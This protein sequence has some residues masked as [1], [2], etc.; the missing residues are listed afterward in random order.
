MDDEGYVAVTTHKTGKYG[1]WLV[2]IGED[3]H[4]NKTMAEKW[5]Y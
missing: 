5:P 2:D 1:R 4:I 3:G